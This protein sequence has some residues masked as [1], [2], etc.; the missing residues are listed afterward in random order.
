MQW[1]LNRKPKHMTVS[2]KKYVIAFFYFW[3]L[4]LHKWSNWIIKCTITIAGN[5]A[6]DLHI[7]MYLL[8]CIEYKISICRREL[9]I[10]SS[11]DHTVNLHGSQIYTSIRTS[12]E[13]NNTCNMWSLLILRM[14]IQFWKQQLEICDYLQLDRNVQCKRNNLEWNAIFA[15]RW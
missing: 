7:T 14:V 10:I 9:K 11:P 8:L 2:K 1:S 4:K 6:F 13:M 15:R 12:F 3:K 5:N